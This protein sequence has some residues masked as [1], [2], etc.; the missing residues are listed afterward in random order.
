[1]YPPPGVEVT[2]SLGGGG[3]LGGTLRRSTDATGRATFDDLFISGD[4]G[5][6]TLV[7]TAIGYA[8]VTSDPIE[9][10]AIGTTTTITGDTPDPSGA[11][12]T[13]TVS[14]RV[15]SDGP[16]PTGTVTVSDGVQSCS[17]ALSNG[18]G[19]CTLDLTTV[20]SRTLTA[21]YGGGPGLNGSSDTEPHTVAPVAPSNQPPTAEFATSCDELGC[22]FEDQS[23]DPDGRIEGRSW[24]FGDGGTSDDRNPSHE[25]ASSGT[26]Q[27]S[28][29]VTDN[30]GATRHCHA[31]RYRLG[32]GC[33]YQHHA[34][35]WMIRIPRSPG[36]PFTVTLSVESD[37]G[38]PRG[39]RDCERR[40]ERLRRTDRGRLRQLLARAL[41]PRR[42]GPSPPPSRGTPALPPARRTKPIR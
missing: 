37:D 12:G 20:G 7:F 13:V 33:E 5:P 19:S 15:A 41:H 36:Q 9:L 6:R 1:M 28:L 4:A 38:T 17:G 16:I 3:E 18:A 24:T 23:N 40:G 21:T 29:T 8:Q 2:V 22:R 31:Q 27:V 25:Y 42:P 26:Y 35:R 11:G 34:S 39:H 32:A 14:F 10:V 30:D